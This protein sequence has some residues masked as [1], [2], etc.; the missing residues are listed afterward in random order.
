[1]NYLKHYSLLGHF[2]FWKFW[3]HFIYYYEKNL[4]E[5][6]PILIYISIHHSSTEPNDFRGVTTISDS[7]VFFKEGSFILSISEGSFYIIDECNISSE[8]NMK[9]VIPKLE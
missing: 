7:E 8:L 4:Q 6:K 1:M 3:L 2:F 9:S 5:E